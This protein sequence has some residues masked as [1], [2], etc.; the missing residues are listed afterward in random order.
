MKLSNLFLSIVAT[1][2]LGLA[3]GSTDFVMSKQSTAAINVP[4]DDT[5]KGNGLV[6][7]LPANLT[8]K[9]KYVLNVAYETAQA[10][11]H[12]YP[13]LLQAILLQ[14]TKAG[15]MNSY[16]VAGNEFGLKPNLRYY[17]VAQLKLSAARD[18][19]AKWPELW[20]DFEFQGKTD[21]EVIAKLI[22]NER[23]NIAIASKYI[24]I[25]KSRGYTSPSAIAAA[26]NK[27]PTGARG[28]NTAED[29]YSKAVDQHIRKLSKS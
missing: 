19:L 11:G 22:E 28:I 13:Q 12:K 10:D 18:V 4:I 3:V 9:Q 8:S 26:Y 27:G 2:M 20:K 21:E 23:F 25:L 15:G 6:I 29:K 14:E 16:K 5:V 24:L 1:F 17:G 7:Q